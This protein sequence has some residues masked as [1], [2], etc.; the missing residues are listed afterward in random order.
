MPSMIVQE[1]DHDVI[2]VQSKIRETAKDT[3]SPSLFKTWYEEAHIP[4]LLGTP[5]VSA[6]LRYVRSDIKSPE[7]E[8]SAVGDPTSGFPYLCVYSRID[9]E[10]VHSESCEFV[11]VPLTHEMLPGP[12]G[13]VFEVAD[14]VM[15][16]YEV[17]HGVK[18]EGNF[19]G[20]FRRL[21]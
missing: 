6:A 5:G 14:F 1:G 12:R 13:A 21:L 19:D 9:Y 17:M 10:W 2:F 18:N 16:A 3:L 8:A 11:K 4:D 15:G 7:D 20:M